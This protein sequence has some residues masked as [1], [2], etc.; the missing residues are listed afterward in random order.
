MQ[1]LAEQ[2]RRQLRYRSPSRRL[3]SI[4]YVNTV[5]VFEAM[6]IFARRPLILKTLYPFMQL[7]SKKMGGALEI[8][9]P[10]L[11]TDMRR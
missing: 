4:F 1:T 11:L 8:K 7:S 5:S 10:I 2:I 3:F 6:E 9:L